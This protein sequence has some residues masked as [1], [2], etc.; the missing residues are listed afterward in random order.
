MAKVT[1]RRLQRL[2]W[3]AFEVRLR[4]GEAA[5][6]AAKLGLHWADV[7]ASARF[8]ALVSALGLWPRYERQQGARA[9][10]TVAH[11]RR[12]TARFWAEATRDSS[13]D[14]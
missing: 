13:A 12:E 11:Q 8:C 9:G 2:E 7:R 10:R 3:A 4:R 5:R 14:G 1:G 6:V